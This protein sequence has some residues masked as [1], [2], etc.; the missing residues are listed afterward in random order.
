[1][2][3]VGTQILYIGGTDGKTASASVYVARTVGTGNFDKWADGPALPAPRADASV[4]YV[5][6][7]IYVIGGT[8][9]TGRTD[10]TVFVLSPISQTGRARRVEDRPTSSSSRKPRT[11]AAAAVTPDGLLLIGGRNADGPVDDHL[12]DA[13]QRA[14]RARRV[15]RR[16]SRSSRRRPTRPRSSSA[17]T[18]GCTAAAMRTAR[19]ARSS[20]ARSA[21]PAAEGLPDN[22]D[23]GKLV[24]WDI[25]NAANLPVARTNAAGWGANGAIYL[26]G[27]DDGTGPQS[28][29]LLGGPDDR[30]VTSP[31]GSTSTQMDLPASGLEG[32][33]AVV[34]GPNVILVG[35]VT[36]TTGA[37][38]SPRASGRTSRRMSPFFQLG[39]VGVTVPG[40]KIEGEIGQQLGYLNAAGRRAPST[41]SS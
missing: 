11:E 21:K 30:P 9:A 10:D 38:S 3:Q 32:A 39:L 19:S 1:M 14:G 5:A 25:N 22:P 17:T 33:P 23:E 15:V 7:S 40:L 34:T 13:A 24:R 18:S 12:E 16:G 41:S 4:A 35:G 37:R 8:D 31:S 2:I 6:G 26:A 36:S 20:A 27:G 28:R 29:G